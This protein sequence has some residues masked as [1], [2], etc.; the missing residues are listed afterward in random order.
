M[1]VNI[2]KTLLKIKQQRHISKYFAEKDCHVCDKKTQGKPYWT[3]IKTVQSIIFSKCWE[4]SLGKNLEK[5]IPTHFSSATKSKDCSRAT[6]NVLFCHLIEKTVKYLVSFINNSASSQSYL[7]QR[8]KMARS[9]K[10]VNRGQNL[11]TRVLLTDN[12]SKTLG[13][14]TA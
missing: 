8:L 2:I 10:R 4:E 1:E 5:F 13:F 6:G 11:K 7:A 12:H 9:L 3:F 14:M